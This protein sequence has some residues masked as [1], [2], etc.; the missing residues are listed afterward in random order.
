MRPLR[1]SSGRTRSLSG[2]FN[3]L[4]FPGVSAGGRLAPPPGA[5]SAGGVAQTQGAVCNPCGEIHQVRA[6]IHPA[7]QADPQC[8]ACVDG[9]YLKLRFPESDL[10]DFNLTQFQDSFAD[11][12]GLDYSRIFIESVEEIQLEGEE[13]PSAAPTVILLP[14]WIFEAPA[15]ATDFENTTEV[16]T[17]E[18]NAT[19]PAANETSL[20]LNE[21]EPEAS[22][23][24]A[25]VTRQSSSGASGYGRLGFGPTAPA[26]APEPETFRS[27]GRRRLAQTETLAEEGTLMQQNVTA[28]AG[29]DDEELKDFSDA[30]LMGLERLLSSHYLENVGPFDYGVST[31]EK[32]CQRFVLT[33]QQVRDLIASETCDYEDGSC[34]FVWG[35]DLNSTSSTLTRQEILKA[36]QGGAVGATDMIYES[37]IK[38]RSNDTDLVDILENQIPLAKNSIVRMVTLSML[39]M[40]KDYELSF[41]DQHEILVIGGV[42]NFSTTTCNECTCRGEAGMKQPYLEWQK[43][44]ALT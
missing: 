3:P 11:S 17:K 26:S 19:T 16:Y 28:A 21:T 39:N 10:D 38:A 32:F 13:T 36:F 12:I 15:N 4:G 43:L 40:G 41:G 6:R 42:A 24:A 30:A 20:S 31:A 9:I 7:Y 35:K 2:M 18:A 5:I 1:F 44:P 27:G 25:S 23:P 8:G 14:E 22:T 34:D 33:D 29:G 37:I